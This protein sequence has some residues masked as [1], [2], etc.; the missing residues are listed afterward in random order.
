MGPTVM[1]QAL[2]CMLH[3]AA[4]GRDEHGQQCGSVLCSA[5]PAQQLHAAALPHDLATASLGQSRRP[6]N[7]VW[8]GDGA[9]LF[10]HSRN[11]ALADCL[12]GWIAAARISKQLVERCRCRALWWV[13]PHHF[14]YK[15]C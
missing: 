11:Q 7:G 6:V 8:G 5:S 1:Q 9:D 15:Q 3:A 14:E 10:P 13:S 12:I 4:V 2:T